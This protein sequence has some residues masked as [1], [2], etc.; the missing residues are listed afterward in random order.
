MDGVCHLSRNSA[1]CP[2][3]GRRPVNGHLGRRGRLGDFRVSFPANGRYQFDNR[4]KDPDLSWSLTERGRYA[5]Q[6]QELTVTLDEYFGEIESRRY[7]IE[8]LGGS[9][10][11]TRLDFELPP[12][13]YHLRPGSK[14]DV[15]ARNQAEPDLI[16]TWGRPLAFSGK[17]EYTFRPSGYYFVKDTADDTQFPRKS[18]AG[19]TR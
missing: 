17:R 4:S 15:L 9:L 19:D 1:D 13:V 16:G 7:A 5:V 10:T 14:A 3:T 6:G 18:F 12:V 8:L 2:R 11:L